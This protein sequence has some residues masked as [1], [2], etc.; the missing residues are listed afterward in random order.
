MLHWFCVCMHTL[1]CLV[2]MYCSDIITMY[3]KMQLII[4]VYWGSFGNETVNPSCYLQMI[5]TWPMLTVFTSNTYHCILHWEGYSSI[6]TKNSTLMK[7]SNWV[8]PFVSAGH[9]YSLTLIWQMEVLE[10][11][12]QV[13][14]IN[15]FCVWCVIC[16]FMY[17]LL[18]LMYCVCIVH[19]CSELIICLPKRCRAFISA[20]VSSLIQRRIPHCVQIIATGS[21]PV[22]TIV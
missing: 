9:V 18:C 13:F 7:N 6:A 22:L 5:I 19:V 11:C 4:H 1:S 2:F 21:T 15:V 3:F 14:F 10:L 12:D 17:T 8:V 20:M 16:E